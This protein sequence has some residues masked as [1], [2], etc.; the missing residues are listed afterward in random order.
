MCVLLMMFE[1]VKQMQRHVPKI[2]TCDE[3]VWRD[4]EERGSG[5][6]ATQITVKGVQHKE[7]LENSPKKEAA[8]VVH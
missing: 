3:R 4:K 8:A 6:A 2:K 7:E 1:I 5:A